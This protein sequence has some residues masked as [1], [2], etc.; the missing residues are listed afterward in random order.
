MRTLLLIFVALL[1]VLYNMI[2]DYSGAETPKLH[3]PR[4]IGEEAPSAEEAFVAEETLWLARA[5]YSETKRPAEMR[6]VAWTIRNRVEQEY[7]GSTYQEVVTAP[8]Q[9]S[10]FNDPNHR[11]YRMNRGHLMQDMPAWEEALYIAESVYAAPS[12]TNPL[13]GVTHYYS[14]RSMRPAGRVPA[15]AQGKPPVK[16]IGDRFRFYRGVR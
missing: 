8:R 16:E 11:A 4:V 7:K 5:I 15:W 14:P 9:F 6:L 1:G 10:A 13:P 3:Q 2:P 12:S